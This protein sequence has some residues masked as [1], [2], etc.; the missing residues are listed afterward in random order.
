MKG[1]LLQ[2]LG[3]LWLGLWKNPFLNMLVLGVVVLVF[4]TIFFDL[5]KAIAS[6]G[7]STTEGVVISSEVREECCGEDTEGWWPSVSYQ[8]SVSGAEYVSDNIEVQDV[9]SSNTDSFAQ[10]VIQRYPVGKRVQVYYNPQDPAV[11]VLE[12]G[13]P[14]NDVGFWGVLIVAV[15][16]GGVVFLVI[17]LLGLVGIIKLPVKEQGPGYEEKAR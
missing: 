5:P 14:N 16:G 2:S 1:N 11:S 8:Y 6:I 3:K 10:E 12:P 9:G 7:W 15:I 4:G 13:I 17:G